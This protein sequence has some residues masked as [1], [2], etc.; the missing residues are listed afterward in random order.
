MTTPAAELKTGVAMLNAAH[1]VINGQMT[2]TE[3]A[4][5]VTGIIQDMWPGEPSRA[6]W[7]VAYMGLRAASLLAT[8]TGTDIQTVLGFLGT[9]T[10]SL[11]DA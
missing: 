3:F 7:P 9:E 2:E 4:R 8:N 6:I 11:P 10:A 1:Q 5:T